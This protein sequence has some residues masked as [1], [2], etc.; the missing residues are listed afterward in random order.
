MYK[1]RAVC[2]AGART[3]SAEALP[4]RSP[5]TC[6][7]SRRHLRRSTEPPIWG[8]PNC[9]LS[10]SFYF[11]Q[12]C[13]GHERTSS[14]IC[15][16]TAHEGGKLKDKTVPVHRGV[17]VER[18]SF[19]TSAL[20]GRKFRVSRT[21]RFN[22]RGKISA[23]YWIKAGRAPELWKTAPWHFME[24][25][26]DSSVAFPNHCPDWAS[27]YAARYRSWICVHRSESTA[28]SSAQPLRQLITF[29]PSERET[30]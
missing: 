25:N 16:R 3:D 24:S 17:E 15:G 7:S 29:L 20:D 28:L 4:D 1:C 19:L 22:P 27:L 21:G 8:S 6:P 13:Q 14:D 26:H 12:L 2:T 30:L 18:H 9:V 5:G 10:R 23:I 11:I